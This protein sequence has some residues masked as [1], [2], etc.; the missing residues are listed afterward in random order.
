MTWFR[1]QTTPDLRLEDTLSENLLRCTRRFV[2]E[3]L[4]T[5]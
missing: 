5:G 4:L 2:D 1:H 3:C